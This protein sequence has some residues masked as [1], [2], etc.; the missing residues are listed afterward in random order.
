MREDTNLVESFEGEEGAT[1]TF[2]LSGA[3]W[4]SVFNLL[5]AW[6]YCTSEWTWE[7]WTIQLTG[8]GAGRD[9]LGQ[10]RCWET[11]RWTISFIRHL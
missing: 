1:T 6:E 5:L 10:P 8:G 2:P 3:R 11:S 9:K 7:A 4:A